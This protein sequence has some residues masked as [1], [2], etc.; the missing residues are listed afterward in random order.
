MT[1]S[2]PLVQLRRR[3]WERL[4]LPRRVLIS[5]STSSTLRGVATSSS[6]NVRGSTPPGSRDQRQQ[7]STTGAQ[8]TKHDKTKAVVEPQEDDEEEQSIGV[9]MFD[10]GADSA[11]TLTKEEQLAE[12]LRVY[13]ERRPGQAIRDFLDT[14]KRFTFSST[15]DFL[16][17][18][19][20][21][22]RVIP[23]A[24][25][26]E[27]TLRELDQSQLEFERDRT[28]TEDDH[29]SI[30]PKEG[31][32][33]AAD[34]STTRT[35]AKRRTRSELFLQQLLLQIREVSQ[36]GTSFSAQFMIDQKLRDN[37]SFA[38]H[39]LAAWR[40]NAYGNRKMNETP[41]A[42]RSGV[43]AGFLSA[44]EV[45]AFAHRACSLLTA[46]DQVTYLGGSSLDGQSAL[47]ALHWLVTL[48]DRGYEVA[49]PGVNHA[50]LS[51]IEG[52]F[53]SGRPIVVGDSCAKTYIPERLIAASRK[54]KTG[55]IIQDKD[56]NSATD[57]GSWEDNFA[58]D[59][60]Q[61][62][63]DGE[64]QTVRSL[65]DESLSVSHLVKLLTLI[66]GRERIKPVRP[67]LGVDLSSTTSTEN[68]EMAEQTSRP[69][70]SATSSP[71]PFHSTSSSLESLKKEVA[72]QWR[73]MDP[74]DMEQWEKE[75]SLKC[76]NKVPRMKYVRALD[77]LRDVHVGKKLKAHIATALFE[78]LNDGKNMLSIRDLVRLASVYSVSNRVQRGDLQMDM[79]D[80]LCKRLLERKTEALVPYALALSSAFAEIQCGAAFRL[81]RTKL[82]PACTKLLKAENP[83]L[84]LRQEGFASSALLNP[85]QLDLLIA[86][87][88]DVGARTTTNKRTP[89]R[90][91]PFF[92]ELLETFKSS[93]SAVNES[94]ENIAAKAQ[95][96][97][98]LAARGLI[99]TKGAGGREGGVDKNGDKSIAA[100]VQEAT[101]LLQLAAGTRMEDPGDRTKFRVPDFVRLLRLFNH[102]AGNAGSNSTFKSSFSSESYPSTSSQLDAIIA[103]DVQKDVDKKRKLYQKAI[104]MLSAH[105][106]KQF[107]PSGSGNASGFLGDRS[108]KTLLDLEA[109]DKE[110][111]EVRR[112]LNH[113]NQGGTILQLS[114]LLDVFLEARRCCSSSSSDEHM[115][116]VTGEDV[117]QDIF[118]NKN[119]PSTSRSPTK[120]DADA[121]D[122]PIRLLQT[123]LT[124]PKPTLP[125]S[126]GIHHADPFSRQDTAAPGS[127]L[128][129]FSDL[130][131][132]V[133][134]VATSTGTTKSA[135]IAIA[136]TKRLLARRYGKLFVT[137]CKTPFVE[138]DVEL[139]HLATRSLLALMD[140]HLVNT[141]GAQRQ[142]T[143]GITPL[144]THGCLLT[145]PELTHLLDAFDGNCVSIHLQVKT[146][147]LFTHAMATD[148]CSAF[149]LC[150]GAHGIAEALQLMEIE[151]II[152]GQAGQG[153]G[154]Q[155]DEVTT[156]RNGLHHI[157][158]RLKDHLEAL[159]PGHRLMLLNAIVK[160]A[161]LSEDLE[162][163]AAI[164]KYIVQE[165]NSPDVTAAA[166]CL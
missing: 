109:V 47:V 108:A 60:R 83:L 119:V 145:I 135:I 39:H 21:S 81:W 84:M 8:T 7:P 32:G 100:L 141:V 17:V 158:R 82:L 6:T 125:W 53:F 85:K 80:L 3:G 78:K 127:S 91:D 136:S 10:D 5:S 133:E 128:N 55:V 132:S 49:N 151:G 46:D 51:R 131:S 89:S 163:C 120:K 41:L 153:Q 161:E 23:P 27:A 118:T 58:D 102:Y 74:V 65:V 71:S 104:E 15:E 86:T 110:A 94:S 129:V 123:A 117:K 76:E 44:D 101:K 97:K 111:T 56:K 139:L 113:K 99:P 88:A 1:T 14:S 63:V 105:F 146:A 165:S 69:P 134:N 115:H 130:D 73:S 2:C 36:T 16:E 11:P 103:K 48:A 35:K 75:R 164:D 30:T 50:L 148:S 155:A 142:T 64:A 106:V 157:W 160:A 143:S 57:A 45:Y 38:Q 138:M 68:Y 70:T 20:V 31:Q 77:H 19:R 122:H 140:E 124:A 152:P 26:L 24:A 29:C 107:A 12:K 25:T 87:T 18:L 156:L 22:L 93:A 40:G 137:L 92:R 159:A 61:Q 149:D 98:N 67:V 96:E 62:D 79:Q 9:L 114:E 90:Q 13:R 34:C 121:L 4:R 66:P 72:N 33:E 37:S 95:M 154:Q 147:L 52:E 112:L 43:A 144:S 59:Q 150:I 162:F 126:V 166:G 116:A 42:L 54:D 28:G